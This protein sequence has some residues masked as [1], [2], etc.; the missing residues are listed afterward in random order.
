MNQ[1]HLVQEDEDLGNVRAGGFEEI[2]YVPLTRPDSFLRIYHEQDDVGP[3]DCLM[4]F[5]DH[6]FMPGHVYAWF[7]EPTAK[8]VLY[9][10][11]PGCTLASI[12]DKI[13]Y[14]YEYN[15]NKI[16]FKKQ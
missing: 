3:F 7:D 10:W 11:E 8:R 9:I 5:M 1:I 4:H 15:G 2:G 6:E 16:Y 13:K 14:G 12:W